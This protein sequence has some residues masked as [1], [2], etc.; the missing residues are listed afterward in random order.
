MRNEFIVTN[1]FSQHLWMYKEKM[2]MHRWII[3]PWAEIS[4]S[5]IWTSVRYMTYMYMFT[6]SYFV[7]FC[8]LTAPVCLFRHLEYGI[9]HGN[10]RSDPK[11]SLLSNGFWYK[12]SFVFYLYACI[13][14]HIYIVK[15]CPLNLQKITLYSL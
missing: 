1:S 15:I 3:H 14:I 5:L 9:H 6:M 13:Y 2:Y 10:I 12:I 4:F 8:W 11:Q 7:E